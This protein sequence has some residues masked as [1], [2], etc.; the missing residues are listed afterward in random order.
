MPLPAAAFFLFG[1]GFLGAFLIRSS[2]AMSM[3]MLCVASVA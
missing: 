2:S 3:S 1:R